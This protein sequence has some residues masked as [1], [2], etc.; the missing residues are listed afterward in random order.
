MRVFRDFEKKH[1]EE[2]IE[3]QLEPAEEILSLKN[4][5]IGS[6]VVQNYISFNKS[7]VSVRINCVYT[8]PVQQLKGF[9]FVR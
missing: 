7:D 8:D 9:Y 5:R 6:K 3:N 1:L 4:E 2:F